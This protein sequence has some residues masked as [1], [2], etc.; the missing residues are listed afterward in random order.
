MGGFFTAGLSERLGVILPMYTRRCEGA[1]IDG[2]ISG[3]VDC[4][5]AVCVQ[6]ARHR[7]AYR[8]PT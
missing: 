6:G 4:T 1:E 8:H 5:S 3:Y 7:G 2:Y